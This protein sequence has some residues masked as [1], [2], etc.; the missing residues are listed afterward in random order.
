MKAKLITILLCLF[1]LNAGA[2]ESKKDYSEAFK[3][4]EVWLD[5]QKD[6]EKLPGISAAIVKDQE[7]IW[8]GAF[9]KANIEADVPTDINTICSICS[10]SKLFTAT[11]IM[12]LYDE[13]KLRLDDKVNDLLPWY[14]LDQKYPDSGPITVRTLLTHSSGLP[15]EA[16]FP[17]WTGPDF[18]FPSREEIQKELG[19]QETLYPASTYFQYSNLGLTLLGEIVEQVSGIS[20]KAY[21]EENI[22]KPL[23]LNDTRTELP[24]SFYGGKLAIGYSSLNR[25]GQ[26]NK[27]KLFQANGITP[28]AGFSSNVM[29][30]GKFA[31]WQFRVLDSTVTEILKPST[32]KYMQQVHWTDPDWKTTWGLGFA[33]SKGSDGTTWV[34]HGGSCPGYRS[35]IQLNP[36]SKMAYTVMINANGTNP[37]KYA[38]EMHEILNKVKDSSNKSKGVE[39]YKKDLTEYTGYFSNQPWGSES[40]ISTW[41]GKLVIL[42]LPSQTPS[43]SM[44][45][46][47]HVKGDSF[48]KIRDDE[49]PGEMIVFERDP[50]GKITKYSQHGN[51]STKIKNQ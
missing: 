9:G 42:N 44:I 6:Y 1:N 33:V 41:E 15:R 49:E 39:T 4:I 5:A 11:A 27:V 3:I 21:I 30:L 50:S 43:K 13:G 18:P 48:Q 40:Y 47:K 19:E 23:Q 51:Y 12:K 46:F 20:Y 32:L 25:E 37:H 29:D 24:E 36:K 38:G 16:N 26:R 7:I 22:L 2:Q 31:A 34:S 45:F 8:S 35:G 28:A 10:I 17:Y 14:N